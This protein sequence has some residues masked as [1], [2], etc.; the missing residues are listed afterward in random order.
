MKSLAIAGAFMCLLPLNAAH[1]AE[2]TTYSYDELGRLKS[3]VITGGPNNSV[4]TAAAFD[5]LG[6]R[7]SYTSGGGCKLTAHDTG[8]TDEFSASI[9]VSV[10]GSCS[11]PISLAFSTQDGSAQNNV[12]YYGVSGTIQIT[13][14]D[15]GGYARVYPVYGSV[16]GEE[17]KV[18]Y[19]NFSVQSGDATFV[20]A[21]SAV[22]I[23]TSN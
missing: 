21:Q 23:S 4:S 16:H 9:W 22:T 3:S 15:A 8:T 2:T 12:H 6:N 11:M 19:V 13:S 20:D 5:P 7:T 17:L 1:A 18:F 14:I 10:S